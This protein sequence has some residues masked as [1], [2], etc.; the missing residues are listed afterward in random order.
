MPL[1]K[2]IQKKNLSIQANALDIYKKENESLKMRIR[3]LELDEINY[4]EKIQSL[5]IDNLDFSF[6]VIHFLFCRYP[7][8]SLGWINFFLNYFF[9]RHSLIYK[10]LLKNK[11]V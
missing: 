10:I 5:E 8:Q 9:Q 7:N 3:T 6:S 2:I 1:K 11:Y 4:Q